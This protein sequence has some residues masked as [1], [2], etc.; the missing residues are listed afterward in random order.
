MEMHEHKVSV[1]TTQR[2]KDFAARFTVSSHLCKLTAVKY[3][4]RHGIYI[5]AKYD[6]YSEKYWGTDAQ[7]DDSST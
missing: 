2:G 4:G 1:H 3:S 6:S 7:Y 5:P